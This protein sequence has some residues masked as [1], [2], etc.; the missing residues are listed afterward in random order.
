M[1]QGVAG[2]QGALARLADEATLATD[3]LMSRVAAIPVSDALA[4]VTDAYPDIVDPFVSAAGEMTAQWYGELRT[5]TVRRVGEILTPEPATIPDRRALGTSARWALTS[6]NPGLAIRGST[7]RR[8]FDQS[9]R[10]VRDNARRD[11]VRW[12]RHASSDACGF[13]RML[14]TRVLT[15]DRDGA[16]GLYNFEGT[17]R[18]SPHVKDVRGH[19]HCK[20]IAT[21]ANGYEPPDYVYD[22]LE[23]YDAV[24]RNDDGVLRPE[25]NIAYRM[26]RR[27]DDRLGVPRRKRGRPRTRPEPEPKTPPPGANRNT[28]RNSSTGQFIGNQ[29]LFERNAAR[30]A[31]MARSARERVATANQVVSRADNYAQKAVEVTGRIKSVVDAADKVLGGT[32]PVVRDIKIVVDAANKAAGGAAQVTGGAARTV[33][34]VDKTIKDTANIAHGVKQIADEAKSVVDDAV[35]VIA[36]AKALGIEAANLARATAVSAR[37]VNSFADLYSKATATYTEALRIQGAA[38]ELIDQARGAVATMQGLPSGVADLPRVLRAPLADTRKLVDAAR[39]NVDDVIAA[40]DD[41]AA[42]ARSA[43]SLIDAVAFYRRFGAADD[44]AKKAA[45]A[46]TSR[47]VDE[48]GEL[49]DGLPAGAL[50]AA[51]KPP[52]WVFSERLELPSPPSRQAL[53]TGSVAGAVDDAPRALEAPPALRALPAAPPKK[54]R[55]KP[56]QHRNFEDIE[57]DMHA[58]IAAGDDDLIDAFADELEA[59]EKAEKA[60][61]AR[62]AKKEAAEAAAQARRLDEIDAQVERLVAQGYT[63][64]QAYEEIFDQNTESMARSEFIDAARSNGH[65]GRGFEELLASV[66][67]EMVMEEYLQCSDFCRGASVLKPQYIGRSPLDLW[68]V[69]DSEARKMM[70]TEAKEWFDQNGRLTKK[71]LREAILDGDQLWNR[72]R[73]GGEDYLQ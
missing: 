6:S 69:Q 58:A 66:H 46:Y 8:V 34:L 33:G 14:A 68:K 4:F 62:A 38:G 41:A 72:P 53:P 63:Q 35:A 39:S 50:P 51:A 57:A 67:R 17:A 30:A 10:T 31:E 56:V 42:L 60:K 15:T 2:F 29:R 1:S 3:A 37:E 11:G 49:V 65:Q 9:R 22:W 48:M 27:A 13:C 28:N 70:S 40:A 26:E 52:N 32:V 36:G 16:P 61:A 21:I 18:R 12:V 7:T 64:R 45:W 55:K 43:R 5:R 24:S 73:S 71:S 23:D 47:V 54:S 19:D 25:W 44:F 59:A 20:C